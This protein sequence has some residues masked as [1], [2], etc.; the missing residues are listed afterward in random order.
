MRVGK[1]L[2]AVVLSIIFMAGN[3]VSAHRAPNGDETLAD[4]YAHPKNYIY[5][6]SA[7]TGFSFFYYKPSVD[8]QQYNPP[9]YI[10]AARVI[11]RHVSPGETIFDDSMIVKFR[12][13]YNSRKMWAEVLDDN[14]N[15]T[16][17][18][19]DPAKSQNYH[20]N[21]WVAAGEVLFYLAY[22]MSFFDNPVTEPAKKIAS[23]NPQIFEPLEK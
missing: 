18:E 15:L 22:N 16:W 17:K 12:Y 2:A 23:G 4:M 14:R 10:I 8:V 3:Y 21:N 9:N 19:I 20:D 6:A 1:F 5:F 7:S 11:T 13:D